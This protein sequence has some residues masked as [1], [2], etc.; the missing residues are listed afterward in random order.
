M[1]SHIVNVREGLLFA[2]DFIKS[3]HHLSYHSSSLYSPVE[4]RPSLF[5]CYHQT[6]IHTEPGQGKKKKKKKLKYFTS[7]L[8]FYVFSETKVIPDL[9]FFFFLMLHVFLF[10]LI[11]AEQTEQKGTLGGIKVND[12]LTTAPSAGRYHFIT[13]PRQ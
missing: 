4:E 11:N 5:V 2:F 8:H 7:M 9:F 6:Q 12:S 3:K 13:C 10:A 1:Q